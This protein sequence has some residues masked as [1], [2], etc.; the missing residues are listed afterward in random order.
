VR[1]RAALA[2]LAL[3]ASAAAA[4][5]DPAPDARQRWQESPHGAML[6]RILPDAIAPAKLPQPAS[7]G[8]RLARRYCV[9]C[10]NLP[11]PA[12]HERAKWA[13][14][15]ERMVWRMQG[16]GNMG[17]LM[18]DLMAGVAAPDA[19]DARVLTRYLERNAQQGID[20]ARYPDLD[21]D[22]GKSFRLACA[23]CHVLPDPRRHTAQ[24][25]PG[26]VARMQRNMQWMNRVVGSRP[27]AREP[28][29]RVTEI[30][31]FLQRHAR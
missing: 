24:E 19:E 7:R 30:V 11:N 9:Q 25:W 22:A 12:M 28:Q 4:A 2:A 27:D 8:A 29:L 21:G 20:A 5:P 17:E 13:G 14:I 18:Q 15:V 23:Q 31:G 1:R 10:H 16:R 6:E 26:V 3:F